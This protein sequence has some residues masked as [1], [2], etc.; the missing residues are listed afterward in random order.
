MEARVGAMTRASQLMASHAQKIMCIAKNSHKRD[1]KYEKK[2]FTQPQWLKKYI[3]D[4]LNM[5]R[6]VKNMPQRLM[7]IIKLKS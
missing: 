2:T 5:I 3:K 7:T 6:K 4:N 1:G